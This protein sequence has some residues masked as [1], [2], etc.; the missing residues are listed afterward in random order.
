LAS[1]L[2]SYPQCYPLNFSWDMA[3]TDWYVAAH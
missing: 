2:P 3:P 1:F